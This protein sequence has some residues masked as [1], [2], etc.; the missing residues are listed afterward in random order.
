MII[1]VAV[2]STAFHSGSQCRVGRQLMCAAIESG[3]SVSTSLLFCTVRVIRRKGVHR[4][5]HTSRPRM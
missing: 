3:N 2:D 4:H 5:G 1:R